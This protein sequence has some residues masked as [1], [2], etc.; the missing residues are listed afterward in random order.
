MLKAGQALSALHV[1]VTQMPGKEIIVRMLL[2]KGA[3][4]EL[5][6]AFHGS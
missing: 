6:S 3:P 5:Q 2:E 4:L 1:A